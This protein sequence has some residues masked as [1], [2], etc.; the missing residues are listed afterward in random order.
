MFPGRSP[1]EYCFNNPI[2]LTDPTGMSPEGGDTDPLPVGT[3]TKGVPHA[4][5]LN[6]VVVTAPANKTHKVTAYISGNISNKGNT[7]SSFVGKL[8]TF[9]NK[10]NFNVSI[11]DIGNIAMSYSE[12]EGW[13]YNVSQ[14]KPNLD[15]AFK[16]TLASGVHIPDFVA[17]W[18]MDK[19]IESLN[20]QNIAEA[21]RINNNENDKKKN[22]MMNY[23]LYS[24]RNLIDNDIIEA[25]GN[26]L[27]NSVSAKFENR[28]FNFGNNKINIRGVIK[29]NLPKSEKVDKQRFFRGELVKKK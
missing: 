7:T 1:Y 17:T 3:V 14:Y 28:V 22:E 2:N 10:I 15:D 16:S 8:E 19:A 25:Y 26:P 24:V 23:V 29:Y 21:I 13:S 4:G 18:G 27:E 12:S 20:P 6:E 5:S 9:K 11:Q